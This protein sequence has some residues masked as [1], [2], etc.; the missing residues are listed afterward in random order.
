[1]RVVIF[2]KF[3]S[4]S[5]GGASTALDLS[6]TLSALGN[7]VYLAVAEGHLKYVLTGRSKCPTTI[8]NS[9]ILS[10]PP[11]YERVVKAAD[12]TESFKKK[13]KRLLNEILLF[14]GQR[15]ARFKRVLSKADV[16]IYA[17]G[18]FT[19][20]AF[21]E[22]RKFTKAHF[23]RNHAGSPDTYENEAIQ[24]QH[25]V[26]A[27]VTKRERYVAYCKSFEGILF[28]A[29]AQAAECIERDPTLAPS[30]YVV[31]PSC[32][33]GAVVGAAL[34]ASPYAPS[35]RIIVS[36]GSLQPRKDQQA[37]LKSFLAIAPEFPDLE[38]HFVGGK[39]ESAYGR[40][41]RS[42][43][44]ASGY[45]ERVY[46]HGH[47]SNYLRYMAHA[48]IMVQSSQAEGVSRVL[49]EAMLLKTPIVSFAISGT[50]SILTNEL[51]ALLVPPQDT[52]A[53]GNALRRVLKDP[54]LGRSMARAAYNKYLTHHSWPVY[55]ASLANMLTNLTAKK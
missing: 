21:L 53:L 11:R 28:Q 22:M 33:E 19:G 54:E 41:L 7:D 14:A 3:I 25:V 49:R 31:H 36:V 44:D 13:L 8:P 10:I 40:A 52:Q 24:P 45:G 27:Y 51:N 55:A 48:D 34:S 37:A 26:G 2:V 42:T 4:R 47:R 30:C 17:G 20:E 1:M 29:E 43:A 23:V 5:N 15:H 6:E 38:L 46:L 39:T 16:V 18:G 9:R 50:S 35:K 12:A 32:N